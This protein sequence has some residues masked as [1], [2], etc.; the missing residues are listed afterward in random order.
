MSTAKRLISPFKEHNETAPKKIKIQM[1]E[2]LKAET[3]EEKSRDKEENYD[4][5]F[6]QEDD[7][8]LSAFETAESELSKKKEKL[9]LSQWQRCVVQEV[10]RDK[11]TFALVI[12]VSATIRRE[13]EE[14][15]EAEAKCYL[16]GP[17]C[18]TRISVDSVVSLLAEW[19]ENLQA[20]KVDKDQGFCVINPDTLISG[21]SVVGSLFCRRKA[22]LQDR[23]RGIDANNKVVSTKMY[24]IMLGN[25]VLHFI[26]IFQMVIGSLVHELLQTV[27]EKN[28][29]DLKAIEQVAKDLLNSQET[30]FMLYG[31]QL[32]REDT[33]LEVLQF[34]RSIHQFM[35]QYVE[36]ELSCTF[37]LQKEN[38]QGRITEIQDIEE[39]LWIPQMGLKG[40]IDVSVKIHPRRQK[41]QMA[42]FLKQQEKVVPLELKTGRASFSMEHK[43]QLILY[44]MMLSALG[45]PTQSGLLLYLRETLMR[46]IVGSRNEQRDLIGLRNDL[47]HYLSYFPDFATL[48]AS[49]SLKEEK[50]I[51]PFELPEPISH[52]TACSQCAYAT[53][54]CSFA[55]TDNSLELRSSHPLNKVS[56]E[57]ISHLSHKDY[58]YFIKWCHLLMMEEQESR[59]SNYSRALW[60]QTSESRQEMG[61][62][63]CGLKI[64]DKPIE[65]EETRYKHQFVLEGKAN[66]SLQNVEDDTLDLTLSGVRWKF[67]YFFTLL[68]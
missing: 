30:A 6:E 8:D 16:Q 52:P 2:D 5:L 61:R 28:L 24:F 36:E 68:Y 49:L 33:T 43:G 45:K 67:I 47:S 11:K 9:D 48:P 20:Y 38:F 51:Q 19:D 58:E 15:L 22:V 13:N 1:S 53:L 10:D 23:F 32:T 21:T 55:K 60:C 12:K 57:C 25:I 54:C 42:N 62:A 41:G 27:L 40:K 3:I 37:P 17:W 50:F 18:H 35:Q 59:K 26:Y 66:G 34:V 44:Q 56:N 29:R 46:E 14:E 39:N 63:I 4:F 64:S 31:S 7:F 65:K